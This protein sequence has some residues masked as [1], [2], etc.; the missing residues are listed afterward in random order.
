MMAVLS[1]LPP[2]AEDA[3]WAYELKW[4]GERAVVYVEG[5]RVRALSRNEV[6]IT[7]SYPELRLLGEA[8]GVTQ[9]VLDGELVAFDAEGRPSFRRLQERM[10]VRKAAD[11][12]RVAAT[13]PV[14]YLIF[15]VLHLDGRSTLGLPYTERRALLEGLGLGGP[16]WQTTPSFTGG[17]GDVLEASRQHG[18]E[19][20]LAKRLTSQYRPGRRSPEWRKVKNVRTQEVVIAG[21]RPGQ[22]R[23][24]GELGALVLGL[25]TD[26]GF[27]YCGGVGTGFT[28]AMRADLKARLVRLERK[29]PPYDVDVP[30]ERLRELKDVHWVTPKL[31]GE[32]AFAE[33]TDDGR[34][35]HPTWRGLRPDKSPDQVVRES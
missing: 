25:H 22:G 10:H 26:E 28:A 15:D 3:R 2:A 16:H 24:T 1:E 29:T 31:V 33:W 20:V 27:V 17:G 12:R 5:G 35:R 23:F 18:F 11:V 30:R 21:W 13:V 6:D 32:V 4:D 7:V 19:G 14:T 9:V 34:M 8:L